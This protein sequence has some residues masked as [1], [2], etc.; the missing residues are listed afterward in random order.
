MSNEWRVLALAFPESSRTGARASTQS[1]EAHRAGAA[2][3]S[4]KRFK[5]GRWSPAATGLFARR[6]ERH[7]S[8]RNASDGEDL[9]AMDRTGSRPTT[10]GAGDGCDVAQDFVRRLR[11]H[12]PAR[13]GRE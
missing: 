4:D 2:V 8:T 5:W 11:L 7:R 10:G 3:S 6:R 13:V 1:S 9:T 12:P